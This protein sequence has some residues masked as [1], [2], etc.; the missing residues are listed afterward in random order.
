MNFSIPLGNGLVIKK[1]LQS[2][3]MLTKTPNAWIHVCVETILQLVFHE[4]DSVKCSFVF[5]KTKNLS[6][7]RQF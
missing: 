5:D 7:W 1:S 6:K 2:K 3:K 4:I